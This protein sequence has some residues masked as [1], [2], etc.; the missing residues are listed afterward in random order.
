VTDYVRRIR[1]LV[2]PE[3][4]LHLPSVSV[5]VRD[6]DGRV[7]LARHAEGNRWLLPG[8]A[9]EPGET[10]ADAAVRE[11]WEETGLVVRLTRLIGVFGGPDFVV[12]YRNGDRASYVSSVFEGAIDGGQARPDGTE[13]HELRFVSE[14]ESSALSVAPWAAEVLHAIFG[15]KTATFRPAT[16]T[17]PPNRVTGS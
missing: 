6:A 10:P 17:P 5:A 7:L 9:I 11:A 2:G 1:A 14:A 13:L 15:E 16:W 4:L 3:E 8:G 12:H